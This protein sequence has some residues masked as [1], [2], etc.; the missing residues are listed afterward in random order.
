MVESWFNYSI[1]SNKKRSHLRSRSWQPCVSI[2]MTKIK[3]APTLSCRKYPRKKTVKYMNFSKI[4]SR[5]KLNL[6][7]ILHLYEQFIFFMCPR[8]IYTWVENKLPI[9]LFILICTINWEGESS[10]V[11]FFAISRIHDQFIK[12]E[13]CFCYIHIITTITQLEI[14]WTV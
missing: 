12:H 3:F 4:F 13:S 9:H 5:M 11:I 7:W 1:L 14:H 8:I 2:E 6:S 10:H